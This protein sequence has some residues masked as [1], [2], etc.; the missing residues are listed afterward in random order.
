MAQLGS[1]IARRDNRSVRPILYALVLFAIVGIS[2]AT[3]TMSRFGLEDNYIVV[4]SVAFLFAALL[5]G[6]KRVLI[7]IVLVGV[8]AINIPVEFLEPYN[9]D[10]DVLLSIV[11]AIILAP[12]IYD[13]IAN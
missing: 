10:R 5:L 13:L 2:L 1:K 4:V 3:E 9:V 6:K 8:M 12:T 11:C 7:L